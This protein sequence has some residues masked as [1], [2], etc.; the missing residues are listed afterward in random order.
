MYDLKGALLR[1]WQRSI[2]AGVQVNQFDMPAI[3]SQPLVLR[4]RDRAGNVVM[5]SKLNHIP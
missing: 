2:D 1:A 3:G 5:V 4:V